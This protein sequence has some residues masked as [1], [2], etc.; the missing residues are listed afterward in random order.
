MTRNISD[1]HEELLAN[2]SS[3]FVQTKEGTLIPF[4]EW[5]G[6][7]LYSQLH[8]YAG[9]FNPLHDGHK[10]IY[11]NMPV[12]NYCN[13]GGYYSFSGIVHA[14]KVIGT[15]LFELSINRFDKPPV[16][17]HELEQRL[18]QFVGYAPVLITN[19]AKFSEKAGVLRGNY[20]VVF[21]VGADTITRLLNH[22]S[23]QEVAGMNCDFVYYE[24][25][26]NGTKVALSQN[27]PCNCRKGAEI[28][29]ELMKISSTALRNTGIVC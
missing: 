5:T 13:D 10:A 21:H 27:M 1:I 19:V 24:R 4:R 9:S 8:V 6:L 3:V 18:S 26:M 29:E 7:P 2:P 15:S 14:G 17:V 12:G 11:K 20:K 25:I 28:S 22:S 16:S 23:I